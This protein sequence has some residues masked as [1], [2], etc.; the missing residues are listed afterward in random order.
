MNSH[1]ILQEMQRQFER[2][3]TIAADKSQEAL[4]GD[5]SLKE[6]NEQD[7]RDWL[8]KSTVWTEAQAVVQEFG[9]SPE[10]KVL[11]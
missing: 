9:V 10:P 7:A 3:Q 5:S 2:C 4:V 11:I 1:P 6:K 8:L